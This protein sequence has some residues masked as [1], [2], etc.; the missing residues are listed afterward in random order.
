V[1]KVVLFYSYKKFW[2]FATFIMTLKLFPEVFSWG[3]DEGIAEAILNIWYLCNKLLLGELGRVPLGIVFLKNPPVR[4][5]FLQLR[6]VTL[7]RISFCWIFSIVPA[8]GYR[9]PLQSQLKALDNILL[10]PSY[11]TYG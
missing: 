6:V 8:V 5:L 9:G 10:L 3:Q 4:F 11:S 2:W 1:L 7:S